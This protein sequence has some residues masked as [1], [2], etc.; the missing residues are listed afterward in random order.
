M[1]KIEVKTITPQIATEYLGKNFADNRNVRNTVVSQY[2]EDMAND[3]WTQNAEPIKFDQYGNLVD[4]Q[5][6]LQAVIKSGKS[7]DFFVA[8]GL[9]AESTTNLDIGAKRKAADALKIAG[10]GVYQSAQASLAK[11]ILAF[12]AGKMA[13]LGESAVANV[14]VTHAQVIDYVTQNDLS[15]FCH[16]GLSLYD[17]QISRILG[18]T[19]W[20]FL[21][22]YLPKKSKEKYWNF[23]SK[24]S[25]LEDVPAIS[26]VRLLFK[27][28]QSKMTSSQKLADVDAAFEAFL[29]N[30]SRYVLV[31][32]E[33][34]VRNGRTAASGWRVGG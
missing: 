32:H 13:L 25:T 1:I 20:I 10:I 19:D 15:G 3:R 2:A 14:I 21:C 31:K 8:T 5:H 16:E 12:E 34:D 7:V 9:P 28:L 11:R 30:R 33:K 27:R 17:K 24:L 29:A 26:P 18:P 22:W 23:L 4:G 6:R